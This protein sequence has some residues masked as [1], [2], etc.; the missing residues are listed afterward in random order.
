MIS[1]KNHMQIAAGRAK[2]AGAVGGQRGWG[3][4]AEGTGT[5]VPCSPF[6]P[7]REKVPE[8]RMMGVLATIY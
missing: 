2:G 5:D 4:D 8:G 7:P 3:G 1:E 6:S